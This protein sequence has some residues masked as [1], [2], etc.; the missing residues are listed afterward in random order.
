M[1]IRIEILLKGTRPYS[2]I[3]LSL[4]SSDKKKKSND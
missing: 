4:Y 3:F 1:E 2:L